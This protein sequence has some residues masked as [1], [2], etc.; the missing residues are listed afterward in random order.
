MDIGSRWVHKQSGREATVL[1]VRN[2]DRCALVGFQ[3]PDGIKWRLE[4]IFR[5]QYEPAQPII[6]PAPPHFS[7]AQNGELVPPPAEPPPALVPAEEAPAPLDGG[8]AGAVIVSAEAPNA[9]LN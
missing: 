5:T 8:G 4:P 7:V 2:G 3:T 9:T 6:P 1:E